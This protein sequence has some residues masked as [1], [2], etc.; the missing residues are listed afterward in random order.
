M[1]TLMA[2]HGTNKVLI[3]LPQIFDAHAN[4]A[5]PDSCAKTGLG[6]NGKAKT[7]N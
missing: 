1:T 3:I 2:D 7:G 4:L 5:Y 6:A